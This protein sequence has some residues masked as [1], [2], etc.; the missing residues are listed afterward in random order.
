MRA[1][2]VSS[3][4]GVTLLLAF[5]DPTRDGGYAQVALSC[6]DLEIA[7]AALALLVAW[8]GNARRPTRVPWPA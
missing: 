6:V 5:I 4:M 3:D 1:L 7:M 2:M 8:A